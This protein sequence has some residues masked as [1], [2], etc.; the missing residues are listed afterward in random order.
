VTKIDVWECDICHERFVRTDEA[1]SYY[2]ISIFITIPSDGLL[3]ST[4]DEKEYALKDVCQKCRL[5]VID[6]LDK[7]IDLEAK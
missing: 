7:V 5:K 4:S 2:P 3:L 6:A 1:G